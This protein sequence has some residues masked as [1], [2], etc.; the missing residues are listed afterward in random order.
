MTVAERR[1]RKASRSGNEGNCVEVAHTLDAVRDSKYAAGPVLAVDA[2][3]LVRAVRSGQI[4][5]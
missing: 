3:A 5:R 2:S 1:W 4:S